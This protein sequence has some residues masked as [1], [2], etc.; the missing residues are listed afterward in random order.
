LAG[1]FFL[2]LTA[3]GGLAWLGRPADRDTTPVVKGKP[4]PNDVWRSDFV[5]WVDTY[6]MPS[7]GLP[8]HAI[9]LYGARCGLVH[10]QTAE[11]RT[12]REV[13]LLDAEAQR[14]AWC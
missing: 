7:A 13:V 10:T 8:V 14:R 3:I 5:A 12:T 6:V 2:V 1:A 9:D 11:S 4:D